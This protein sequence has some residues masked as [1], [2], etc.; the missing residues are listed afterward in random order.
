MHELLVA[1]EGLLRAVLF[2]AVTLVALDPTVCVLVLVSVLGV[3]ENLLAEAARVT[4]R[5]LFL[6]VRLGRYFL[7]AAALIIMIS[8]QVNVEILS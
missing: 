2:P 6:A 8:T 5:P 4:V 7:A 1:E 3:E